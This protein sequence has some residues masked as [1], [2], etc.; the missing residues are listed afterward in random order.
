MN[1]NNIIQNSDVL[2]F[3]FDDTIASTEQFSWVAHNKAL[4]SHGVVLTNEY[5]KKYIG[6]N[7]KIIFSMIENDFNIKI[8]FDSHFSKRLDFYVN[9]IISSNLQPF[10]YFKEI[11]QN[12]SDKNFYILSSNSK[13]AIKPILEHWGIYNKF[14]DIYSM[15]D[16]GKTKLHFFENTKQY[17]NA[18]A[19]KITVFED[20]A[21][22]IDYAKLN[23][24]NTVFISN[25][26][27]ENLKCDCDFII[28]T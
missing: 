4:Q 17:F 16:L 1:L 23:N 8:D 5:I 14:V 25:K 13:K 7:D 11:L 20:S 6:N 12:N 27:N 15:I 28:K 22:T 24:L 19:N 10:L 21:K 2:I 26:L 9:E 3:D 18:D